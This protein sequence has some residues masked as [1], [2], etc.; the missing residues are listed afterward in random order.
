LSA[1]IRE[2]CSGG[3]EINPAYRGSPGSIFEHPARALEPHAVRAVAATLARIDPESL[4]AV[5]LPDAEAARQIVG[6]DEF[7]GHPRDYLR[8][9]Y[10][11]LRRFYAVAAAR[12]LA[13]ATWWD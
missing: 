7:D 6:I 10:D 12:G 2:A 1:A 5:L 11:S 8:G 13:T 9:H 3:D 4:V